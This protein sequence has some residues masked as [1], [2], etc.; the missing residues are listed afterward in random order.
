MGVSGDGVGFYRDPLCWLC[1]VYG[2]GQG[3]AQLIVSVNSRQRLNSCASDWV[4]GVE[5]Y[6]N[7]MSNMKHL[8][9]D[10][11]YPKEYDVS[12]LEAIP[13]APGREALG[14]NLQELA[15]IGQDLWQAFEVSWLLDSGQPQMAVLKLCIPATSENIVESKSLKLYLQSFH[16]TRLNSLA[17]LKVKVSTDLETLLASPVTLEVWPLNQLSSV[18]VEYDIWSIRPWTHNISTLSLQNLQFIDLDALQ[19]CCDVFNVQPSL[20]Q[21]LPETRLCQ[22]MTTDSFRSLCPVTGQPDFAS[23]LILTQGAALQP[24][25][26]GQ[27]LA[28]FRCHQGFH[29]QCVET[30]FMAINNVANFEKLSVI[31]RFTRRGG[32]DINPERHKNQASADIA[33]RLQQRQFRQ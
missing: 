29:E 19:F 28:S 16:M 14:L 8:G 33:A 10:T 3:H 1:L 7:E 23:F 25:S 30:V 26:L 4:L 18:A 24:E 22:V 13:R 5:I 20:L 32:I 9:R 2:A 27:Y 15:F 11:D 6:W 31:G 12:L 17:D 21:T